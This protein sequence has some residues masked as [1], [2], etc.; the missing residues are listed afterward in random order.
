MDYGD[1]ILLPTD[2]QLA[3]TDVCLV[4]K[5]RSRESAAAARHR[6]PRR[7][8]PPQRAAALRP[9]CCIAA[10]YPP[11]LYMTARS[12][13][14]L[15]PQAAAALPRRGRTRVSL[16]QVRLVAQLLRL[17]RRLPPSECLRLTARAHTQITLKR[18][19]VPHEP[20]PVLCGEIFPEHERHR[21]SVSGWSCAVHPPKRVWVVAHPPRDPVPTDGEI[22]LMLVRTVLVPTQ[23]VS[24]V[25]FDSGRAAAG[26]PSCSLRQRTSRTT[27]AAGQAP[28]VR[29]APRPTL[30][31]RLAH[32][33]SSLQTVFPQQ[34]QPFPCF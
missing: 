7:E 6:P 24:H 17:L 14:P 16:S 31:Q 12:P 5:V 34:A 1:D 3:E 13:M 20:Q 21:A 15:C 9:A 19:A 18:I 23:C 8:P 28:P 27:P 11:A 2:A 32:W 25:T 26:T 22:A 10:L 4:E 29:Q 33:L 30:A